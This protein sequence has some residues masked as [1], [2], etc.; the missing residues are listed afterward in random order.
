MVYLVPQSSYFSTDA[1]P[2]PGTRPCE[3]M[4][5]LCLP[6]L[7]PPATARVDPPQVEHPRRKMAADS[8]HDGS[9]RRP[10]WR[11]LRVAEALQ[12]R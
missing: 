4:A 9:R 6:A 1:G 3:P 2:L 8:L 12:T 5:I 11:L 7:I 10:T